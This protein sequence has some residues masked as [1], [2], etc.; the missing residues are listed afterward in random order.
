MTDP[1]QVTTVSEFIERAGEVVT[2][3]VPIGP[4][5]RW[6]E[7]EVN[8]ENA[9]GLIQTASDEGVRVMIT[10]GRSATHIYLVEEGYGLKVKEGYGPKFQK[11]VAPGD[12]M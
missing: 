2:V 6:L 3:P 9:V 12:S 7:I 8:K 10:F 4:S 1:E 5:S 11:A